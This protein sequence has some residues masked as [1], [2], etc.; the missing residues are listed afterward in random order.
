MSTR[1]ELE[2]LLKARNQMGETFKAAKA[3]VSDLQGGVQSYGATAQQAS[4]KAASAAKLQAAAWVGVGVAATAVAAGAALAARAVYDLAMRGSE[5]GGVKTA[6]DLLA[7]SAGGANAVLDAGRTGTRGLLTDYDLMI[8]ANRLLGARLPITAAQFGE[9]AGQAVVLGRSVGKDSKESVDRLSL[10]L[11]KMEPELL[12]EINIKVSAVDANKQY[13]ASLGVGVTSLTAYQRQLAFVAAVSEQARERTEALGG[14]HLTFADHVTIVT[15]RVQNLY[16]ELAIGVSL[17]PALMT[18]MS[19]VGSALLNAFGSNQE[20]SI[21]NIVRWVDTFAIKTV[22]AAEWVVK[23]V[24]LMSSTWHGGL[25]LIAAGHGV[26]TGAI[27]VVLSA[28]EKLW[29]LQSYTNPLLAGMYT[30]LADSAAAW[31]EEMKREQEIAALAFKTIQDDGL[32][33]QLA[34]QGVEGVVRD[35]RRSMEDASKA[36]VTHSAVMGAV[37]RATEE[38][39]EAAK[40]TAAQIRAKEQALKALIASLKLNADMLK[41]TRHDLIG[42]R[43]QFQGLTADFGLSEQAAAAFHGDLSILNEQLGIGA[44]RMETAKAKTIDLTAGIDEATEA[45]QRM[46]DEIADRAARDILGAFQTLAFNIGG[47]FGGIVNQW[48]SMLDAMISSSEKNNGKLWQWLSSGT[49][50]KV[51]GGLQIGMQTFSQGMGIGQGLG[52]TG[53]TLVGAGAGAAQGALVGTYLMPGVG[54]ALGAGIGA[55]AGGIGGFLGGRKKEKEEKAQLQELQQ[56]LLKTYGGMDNLKKLAKELGVS[57]DGAFSSKKPK[58]ALA[59]IEKFAL[60]TAEHQ[61]RIEGLGMAIE[62]L[63]ARNANAFG[64]E[65]AS[66][67]EQRAALQAQAGNLKESIAQADAKGS[68]DADLLRAQY[69]KVQTELDHVQ[70]KLLGVGATGQEEFDRL[71]IYAAT[72]LAG[73]IKQTGDVRGAFDAVGPTLDHLKLAQDTLGFA[74]NETI[75]KMLGMR[76]VVEANGPILDNLT[77]LTQ[78]TKGWGDAGLMTKGLFQ[79]VAGDVGAQ[80]QKMIDGGVGVDEALALSGPTLQWLWENSQ[81]YGGITDETTKKLLEQA[82]AQGLVGDHMKS[83]NQQMLEATLGLSATMKDLAAFMRGELP[84]SAG[85][86]ADGIRDRFSGVRITI[87]VEYD[88]GGGYQGGG[89]GGEYPGYATGGTVPWTP[90]GRLVRVAEAGTE[91]IVSDAQLGA[92]V[93]RALSGMQTGGGG[94]VIVRNEIGGRV[95]DEYIVDR[96]NQGARN[97]RVIVPAKAVREQVF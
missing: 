86:A 44:V 6:F 52:K 12:D 85:A 36:G 39:G 22:E 46:R 3:A 50:Q 70:G 90:G 96:V 56:E 24:G 8:N 10:A 34:I 78:M 31:G 49:G 79:T 62:G 41:L 15:N 89:G 48:N 42:A 57:I 64:G 94:T 95:V 73:I 27:G 14:L 26:V 16:D 45:A 2:I 5:I 20:A 28:Q 47:V 72:N 83:V 11:A 93:A 60:A 29:R 4:E 33:S 80:L 37:T 77:A 74:S 9:L 92:I 67:V 59:V 23:G 35:L 61:K 17:S 84:A 76:A 66:L 32:R 58:D 82:E 68:S 71:G 53:G 19:G 43:E 21:R 55:I 51:S 81:K 87:P 18:A 13:A 1:Y 30:K 7:A 65:L 97:G 91:R 40:L 54:T 75:D 69:L 25:L 63:D 88:D 38:E